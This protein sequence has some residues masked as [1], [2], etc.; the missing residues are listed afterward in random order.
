MKKIQIFLLIIIVT[1]LT[2]IVFAQSKA[3]AVFDENKSMKSVEALIQ[4]ENIN[5]DEC[6]RLTTI[7]KV[8]DVSFN[9]DGKILHF[10]LATKYKGKLVKLYFYLPS[11]AYSRLR[12]TESNKLTTLIKKGNRIKLIHYSC[13]TKATSDEVDSIFRL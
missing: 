12:K 13:G 9:I 1:L 3:V 2:S 8:F 11:E 10:R 7:G 6:K 5:N 4:S